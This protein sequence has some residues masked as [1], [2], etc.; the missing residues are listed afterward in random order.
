MSKPCEFGVLQWQDIEEEA[1][2][3]VDETVEAFGLGVPPKR[4]GGHRLWLLMW[5][6]NPRFHRLRCPS[7]DRLAQAVEQAWMDG[8]SVCRMSAKG[9]SQTASHGVKGTI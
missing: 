3:K 6:G 1:F 9:L 5:R 4:V 2:K 8:M 7:R